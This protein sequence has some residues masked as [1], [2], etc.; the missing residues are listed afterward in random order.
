MAI[1]GGI[2]VMTNS[3][4][5]FSAFFF[6]K[7]FLNIPDAGR[8]KTRLQLAA[9]RAVQLMALLRPTSLHSAAHSA[10]LSDQRPG[11]MPGLL[12]LSRALSKVAA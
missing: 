8:F 6:L 5:G 9:R 7:K 11:P 4:F 10:L 12:A 1:Y 2:G 3:S